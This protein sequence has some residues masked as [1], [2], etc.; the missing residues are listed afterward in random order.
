MS[1]CQDATEHGRLKWNCMPRHMCS[2]QV[3]M[4][5]LY[6]AIHRVGW[7]IYHCFA[8]NFLY[9]TD[10]RSTW[11]STTTISNQPWL[12]DKWG[13]VHFSGTL[14]DSVWST[15][16]G[17]LFYWIIVIIIISSLYV[18]T[19]RP[20]DVRACVCK[21]FQIITKAPKPL[22]V[23]VVLNVG[24]YKLGTEGFNKILIRIDRRE[25][26]SKE[27]KC[28]YMVGN[29][30]RVGRG[31]GV[32]LYITLIWEHLLF[33]RSSLIVY[34]IYYDIMIIRGLWISS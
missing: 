11:I 3:Y 15:N 8:P 6:M 29:S 28:S 9:R 34:I 22:P 19:I 4:S 32:G 17:N 23:Q 18:V 5:S 2:R 31:K 30:F 26:T 12:F 20:S 14:W 25:E 1:T 33:V 10:V 13:H 16:P 7:S 24:R 27:N 21:L